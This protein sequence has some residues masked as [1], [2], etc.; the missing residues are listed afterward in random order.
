[1]NILYKIRNQRGERTIAEGEFPIIIGGGRNADIRVKGLK[2]DVEAAYIGLSH[3]RPFVQVGQSE[4]TVRYNDQRLEG[5]AW[6]MDADDLEIGSC[7][8][9]FKVDEDGFIIH[10]VSRQSDIQ[11]VR[12]PSPD[13]TDPAPKIKPLSFRSDRR[14][15][16]AG[17]MTRR[18][19]FIGA[20][21]A[22][23]FLLL[24]I[25]AWFVFTA[26]QITIQI[27]PQPD[28]ISISGS[29]VAPRFGG[30]FLLRPGKYKL[31]AVKECYYPFEEPF[32]VGTQKSQEVRFQMEKLPGRLSLRVH[33]SDDPAARLKG[34]RVIIDGQALG[35]TPVSDLEVAA[36]QRVLEIQAD[37]Y[38]NIKTK[39]QIAGCAQEQ[40]FD[41]ALIP[42][43]S[44]IHISSVP[45]GAAVSV[46]GKPAGFT[47]LTIELPEGNY[48]MEISAAGFK[49]WQRQLAVGLNQPQKITD[50][51]LQPDDGT[52]AL[53]TKPPGANVTIGQKFVGKT[54]LKVQLSANT[55]HE[56]R[57]SKAGYEKV[58]RRV[59]V[60]SGKLKRLAVDLKPE[61]GIIHFKVEPPDARLIVDGE[62]RGVVPSELKLVAVRHQ[63]EIRKQGYK[64]H[65]TLI[66][67]R[68][69]YPQEIKIALTP[70]KSKPTGPMG[71][72]KAQN[73]Y[74]LKLIRP[75]PFT[76]GSS[77]REQG[78]RSNETLRKITLQRPFYMGVKEVSNKEF[79]QFL[80]G[81]TSGAFKGQPLS[82]ADLPVVQVTWEQAALFCNWLSAK[83]SLPPVYIKKGNR[84]VAAEPIGT[85]YRL[86]T[87]AEW[88]YA[89][90][91]IN[92]QTSLKYP[93]GNRYPPTSPSG[94]YADISAKKLLSAYI[95]DY[96][97]GF[98][99]TAPPAKFKANRLGLYDLGGNVAEWCHDFYAIYT[100][101]TNK[102]DVDPTGPAEG[103]HHVVKGSSWK[104]ARMS[105]LRLAYRDY[106]DDKRPDLGFRISRYLE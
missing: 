75:Q 24:S 35:S 21:I 5:S 97:D 100:Y 78:R 15:P 86:P 17:S 2:A 71:V 52:L 80:A 83:E 77:R 26:R 57:I 72:I 65:K 8:I 39:V 105:K 64:T 53:E 104:Y 49:T 13:R 43:W 31:H 82:Q 44:D 84:L 102:T 76:M 93:W 20:A 99:A 90:R 40:S 3:K 36:G 38:Q 59:K 1:M 92:P 74:A 106:S 30:H 89:A 10:V 7:K 68:P 19:R 60:P 25:A 41:F 33:P 66:T 58:S 94:N 62:N 70:I 28:Q 18:G 11:P 32:E 14:Q 45:E 12:P 48:R 69:G 85:G 37:N 91:F 63:F 56:I 27:E 101:N 51:R 6:L 50:I 103:K 47:P 22:L 96:N 95:E 46:D 98:P 81:H 55:P 29:L 73:G 34:A 16:G 9:N 23:G 87:E 4:V 54:P 79:K 42:G 67:P 88:E 61:W